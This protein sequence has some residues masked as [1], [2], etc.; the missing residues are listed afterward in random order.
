MRGSLNSAPK[1]KPRRVGRRGSVWAAGE[2]TLQG[3]GMGCLFLRW[4][5]RDRT[6]T[7]WRGGGLFRAAE[8]D[9]G[10]SCVLPFEA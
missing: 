5:N 6:S 9:P 7:V 10:C 4:G 3:I 2:I 1:E 8:P